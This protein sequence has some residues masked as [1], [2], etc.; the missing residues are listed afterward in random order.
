MKIKI[1]T[2]AFLTNKQ[3]TTELNIQYFVIYLKGQQ[4]WPLTFLYVDHFI[5]VYKKFLDNLEIKQK[6]DCLTEGRKL[7]FQLI[8]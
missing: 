3:K 5:L 6:R 8:D 4:I 1:I 2:D 7:K